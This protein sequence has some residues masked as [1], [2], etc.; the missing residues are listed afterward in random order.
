MI[1]AP[2]DEDDHEFDYIDSEL[3]ADAGVP[4]LTKPTE[5]QEFGEQ[6]FYSEQDEPMDTSQRSGI[7]E[8]DDI[9]IEPLSA[10]DIAAVD[11]SI[12]AYM[13]SKS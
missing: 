6:P 8:F 13:K 1:A 10:D 11:R 5:K 3:F 2:V 9:D 7:D 4:T 12:E